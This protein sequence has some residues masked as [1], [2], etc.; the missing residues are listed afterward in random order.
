MISNQLILS[1]FY[2]TSLLKVFNLSWMLFILPIVSLLFIVLAYIRLMAML[3]SE[4]ELFRMRYDW[5]SEVR[6]VDTEF[7]GKNSLIYLA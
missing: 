4:Q 5:H 1:K 6:M 2:R 7:F 3:D